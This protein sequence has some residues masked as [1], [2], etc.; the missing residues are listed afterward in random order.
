MYLNEP[1]QFDG[2]GRTQ[3]AATL[4]KAGERVFVC[5]GP[6]VREAIEQKH[7]QQADEQIVR[8]GKVLE[9][10]AAVIEGIAADLER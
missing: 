4:V 10:E 8:A 2:R 3:V 6:G 9:N 7:W 1:Y 5:A